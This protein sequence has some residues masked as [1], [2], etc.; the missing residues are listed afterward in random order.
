MYVIVAK[1]YHRRK[2]PK[3]GRRAVDQGRMWDL[4]GAYTMN[5]AFKTSEEAEKNS[6]TLNM[7]DFFGSTGH[8]KAFKTV[9][10]VF[11]V[12]VSDEDCGEACC[13]KKVK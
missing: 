5:R 8:S 11:F 12:N 13:P 2:F 4:I 9:Y 7:E 3:L 1:C 6:L 10:N